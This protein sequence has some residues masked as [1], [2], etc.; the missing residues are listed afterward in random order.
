ML[1]QERITL[2]NNLLQRTLDIQAPLITKEVIIS[3]KIPWF[4]DSI[5]EQIQLQCKVERKWCHEQIQMETSTSSSTER[6]EQFPT[7]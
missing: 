1:L 4:S 2:C 5:R 6:E 7:L 3:N